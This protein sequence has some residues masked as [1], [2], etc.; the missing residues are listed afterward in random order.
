MV[1]IYGLPKA[2]AWTQID[3]TVINEPN[4]TILSLEE[5]SWAAELKASSGFLKHLASAFG[6]IMW[7]ASNNDFAV[8]FRLAANP[9]SRLAKNQA[10]TFSIVFVR[11][12]PFWFTLCFARQDRPYH[13]HPKRVSSPSPLSA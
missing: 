5:A 6:F 7:S 11:F 1:K 8:L 2:W 3:E 9:S 10:S 12:F 4:T 13:D